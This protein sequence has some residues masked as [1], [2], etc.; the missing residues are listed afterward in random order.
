MFGK[1]DGLPNLRCDKV[2][3]SGAEDRRIDTLS[4]WSGCG[5]NRKREQEEEGVR[6]VTPSSLQLG[7]IAEKR[8]AEGKIADS[9]GS[10]LELARE[11]KESS[12]FVGVDA[13]SP[14]DGEIVEP[15][16]KG[17]DS[18]SLNIFWAET[19]DNC[20]RHLGAGYGKGS[21]MGKV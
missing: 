10:S 13:S 4:E 20:V 21:F 16:R 2:H 3:D 17:S 9:T 1:Q 18:T 8:E 14:E 15:E 6:D 11:G 7:E 19:P 5:G 12:G